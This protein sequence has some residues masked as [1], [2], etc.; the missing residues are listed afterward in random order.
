MNKGEQKFE[1]CSLAS[2]LENM[3]DVVRSCNIT[4]EMMRV[5]LMTMTMESKVPSA[6][7]NL[8]QEVNLSS[9]IEAFKSDTEQMKVDSD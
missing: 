1:N 2:T 4:L 6:R 9:E 7:L 8:K 5:E 3:S